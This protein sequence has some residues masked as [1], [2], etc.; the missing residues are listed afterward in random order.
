M[1]KTLAIALVLIMALSMFGCAAKPAA[2]TYEIA[3]VTDV[4]NIGVMVRWL[5]EHD[6][7]VGRVVRV[8]PFMGLAGDKY[9][10]DRR[11]AN[12]HFFK[13][14][15][16]DELAQKTAGLTIIKS[17][18]DS[19]EVNGSIDLLMEHFGESCTLITLENRGHFRAKEKWLPFE[20]PELLDILIA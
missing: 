19:K 1:K 8:A 4:G 14:N 15:I 2:D 16:D 9:D 5:S 18:D 13:F 6:V 3:L 20:F 10:K 11:Y 17:T 12:E 7:K